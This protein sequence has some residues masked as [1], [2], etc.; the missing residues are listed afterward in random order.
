MERFI[1]YIDAKQGHEGRAAG[2]GRGRVGH[3]RRDARADRRGDRGVA[4]A[5]VEAGV[6]RSDVD[7]EDVWRASGA[8]WA[9]DTTEQ[10]RTL[11]R[12]LMDGLRHGA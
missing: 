1:A 12:L 2:A 6:L 4:D 9:V 5:G 10:A 11:L 3:L 8:V 7:A